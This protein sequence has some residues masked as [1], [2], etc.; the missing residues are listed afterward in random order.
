[1][2][3]YYSPGCMDEKA[4]ICDFCEEDDGRP[5]YYWSSKDFDLCC[6]CILNLYKQ[7]GGITKPIVVVSRMVITEELRN[8][9]YKRDNYQCRQCGS[10]NNPTIDHIFPFIKGGKTEKTNLQTLCRLCNSK[11]GAR[12]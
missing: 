9:I 1:M 7:K 10:K 11:K 5:T 2:T 6:D 3:T 8:E 4:H 12:T